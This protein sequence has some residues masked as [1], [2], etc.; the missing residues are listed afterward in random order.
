MAGDW[1]MMR[2]DLDEDP[3]VIKISEVLNKPPIEVVGMCWKLWRWVSLQCHDDSV[4]DVDT[5]E[6]QCRAA[7]T[8]LTRQ[9]LGR[10][11]GMT[12]F[13]AAM[14][15]VEWL[16][17]LPNGQIVIPGYENW[18]SQSAKTRALGAK[19]Q[20]KRRAL[21]CNDGGVTLS[22]S[23]RDRNVTT[24]QDNTVQ[25]RR[26]KKDKK[27]RSPFGEVPPCLSDVSARIKERNLDVDAEAFLAY[28]EARG[29]K[30]GRGQP[31]K[32]WDSCLTTW[33]KNADRFPNG[34]PK[35]LVVPDD[36]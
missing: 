31:V 5:G 13:V 33:A 24:G 14:I 34:K 3:A 6:I 15:E 20:R 32:N 12:D 9:Q 22:R 23:Q 1:I 2:L 4:T 35:P 18:L 11:V 27:A 21:Q 19:R 16:V 7:V 26:D 25:K 28:Y 8:E 10:A 36:F 17:E 29:W 30:L